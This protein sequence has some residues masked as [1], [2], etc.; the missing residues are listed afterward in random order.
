M[1]PGFVEW[2][3]EEAKRVSG[4]VLASTWVDKRTMVLKQPLVSVRRSPGISAGDDH[5]QSRLQL[6]QRVALL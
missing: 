5:A 4:D 2:F 1:V 6:W 3:A